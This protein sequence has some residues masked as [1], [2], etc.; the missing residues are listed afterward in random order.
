MHHSLNM[1]YEEK[2]RNFPNEENC[3]TKLLVGTNPQRK[4]VKGDTQRE[5]DFY[6]LRSNTISE[7]LE[8]FIFYNIRPRSRYLTACVINYKRQVKKMFVLLLPTYCL[9]NSFQPPS[10]FET[11]THTHTHTYV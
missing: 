10:P 9:D 7:F 2:V 11:H 3:S 5:T 4:K 6:T 8:L 1:Y